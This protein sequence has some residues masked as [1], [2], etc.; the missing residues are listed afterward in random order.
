MSGEEGNDTRP[1][2]QSMLMIQP[3]IDEPDDEG[4]EMG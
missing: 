2:R 1:E 3:E 4:G